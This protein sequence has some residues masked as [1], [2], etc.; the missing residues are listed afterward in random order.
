MN[1]TLTTDE[2]M[3]PNEWQSIQDQIYAI[4]TAYM[5]AVRSGNTERIAAI[6][7]L[8]DWRSHGNHTVTHYEVVNASGETIWVCADF[9]RE[10]TPAPYVGMPATIRL[11]TDTMAA[12]VV[13]VSPKSIL[14][15]EVKTGEPVKVGDF[16]PYGHTRA[17]GIIT[18]IIGEP[19]RFTLNK[20]GEFAKGSIGLRLGESY[21]YV[22]WNF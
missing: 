18:E 7:P 10:N 9:G 2:L 8:T 6:K 12:V 21:R 22:N 16:P 13:K 17:E 14:V 3:D 11:Y 4:H 19:Q 1:A 20:H 5:S 15:A